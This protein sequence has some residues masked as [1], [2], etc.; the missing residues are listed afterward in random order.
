[1]RRTERRLALQLLSALSLATL[2]ITACSNSAPIQLSQ[3]IDAPGVLSP[4]A[5]GNAS[6]PEGSAP[7][8]AEPTPC[9]EVTDCA[10][11]DPCTEELCVQGFCEYA[12]LPLAQ[13]CKDTPLSFHA[14]DPESFESFDVYGSTDG[15]HWSLSALRAVSP[16][17]SAHFGDPI[18]GR[19]TSNDRVVG[20]LYLPQVSLPQTSSPTLSFW[21]YAD[22]ESSPHRDSLRIFADVMAPGDVSVATLRLMGKE[23]IP[24]E[25]YEGFVRMTLP[26]D[27]LAGHRVRL[28][29]K[30]DSIVPPNSA[31][32]GVFI[33]DLEIVAH[34]PDDARD[35]SDGLLA[36]PIGD[37]GA[38]GSVGDETTSGGPQ[39]TTITGDGGQDSSGSQASDGSPDG[40]SDPDSSGQSAES[41]GGDEPSGADSAG[42][43]SSASSGSDSAPGSGSGSGSSGGSGSDSAPGSGSGSGSSGS[44]DSSGSSGSSGSLVSGDSPS[45]PCDAPDAHA[46][47][48]TSDADC[49]DGNPA[50]VNVCE[51]AECVAAWSPAGC[52]LDTDCADGEACTVDR[53]VSGECVYEG[54]FGEACCA[55]GSQPVASFDAES[56]EGIFVTDNLETGVFWRPDPTRSTTGSFSLYCGEPVAQTYG[57]GERVK[58]SATTPMLT[59]PVGGQTRLRFD[60]FMVTRP[61]AQL[62]VFQVFVLRDGAL[63]A[64]WSSKVFASGNTM[65][66][67]P[68]DVDLS[69][70]AGQD[71]QLRF[72]FDSVDGHAPGLEGTYLDALRLETTCD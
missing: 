64:V 42:S 10:D 54:T 24:S 12:T 38:A 69:S 66:F 65:G 60:L 59:L 55:P 30:F 70:Y 2:C 37:G 36:E 6:L 57:V 39:D 32:E 21:L 11:S 19:M 4:E 7:F 14:F 44:S 68:I 27:E 17:T 5:L 58:S 35:G 48:C 31:R 9:A 67:L 46:N 41:T 63:T 53:C 25:A 61:E 71:I 1:M 26:M 43:S 50:T 23:A 33:D 16:P 51:G 29:I 20:A 40:G 22:I 49:D 62:D 13:C 15:A 34:C 72:V 45:D 47:C 52:E 56:L 8:G 3:G 18:S 28:R